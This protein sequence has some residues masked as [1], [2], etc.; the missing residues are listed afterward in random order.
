MVFMYLLVACL[1]IPTLSM[2]REFVSFDQDIY[3]TGD[4]MPVF[5]PS[6][7]A[8]QYKLL[9]N[10]ICYKNLEKIAPQLSYEKKSTFIECMGQLRAHIS[11][12]TLKFV[13]EDPT[14]VEAVITYAQPYTLRNEYIELFFFSS[15]MYENDAVYSLLLDKKIDLVNLR[16][17]LGQTP[18]Q[19]LSWLYRKNE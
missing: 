8:A 19:F 3:Y 13:L 11:M 9:Q 10:V 7:Q 16:S 18:A 14:L 2:D 6:E 1:F 12:D 15:L 17:A 5:E 4:L